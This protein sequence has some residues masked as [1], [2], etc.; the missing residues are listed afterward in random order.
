MEEALRAGQKSADIFDEYA[1]ARRRLSHLRARTDSRAS[2]TSTRSL[3]RRPLS[4][5][6]RR[7]RLPCAHSARTSSTC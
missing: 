2:R 4:D 5:V 1:R 3:T 7:A 6:A